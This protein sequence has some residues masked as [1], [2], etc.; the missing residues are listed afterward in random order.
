MGAEGDVSD[1]SVGRACGRLQVT[2]L[3]ISALKLEPRESADSHSKT[4]ST[5]RAQHP[6]F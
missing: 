2:Y 1:N 4:G 6:G 3:P 5:D